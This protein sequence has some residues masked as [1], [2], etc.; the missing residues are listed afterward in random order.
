M[1]RKEISLQKW[2][3]GYWIGMFLFLVA[4]YFLAQAYLFF[5]F[6]NRVEENIQKSVSI[7]SIGIEDSLDV[8]DG[9]IYEALYSGTTQS[10]SQLYNALKNESDPVA[11]LAARSSVVA[12]LKSI[13]TWSDMIDFILLYTDREDEPFWMESGT[14]DTFYARTEVKN[15]LLDSMEEQELGN[16]DR[17][18]I[19]SGNRHNYMLRLIKIEGSYLVVGVSEQ[20]ILSTLLGF[21]YDEGGIA[22]AADE[23]G[24]VIFSSEPMTEQLFLSQEGTYITVN[25]KE[26]LQTGYVSNATGYYFGLLTSKDSIESDM[27]IFRIVFV[28][29]FLVLMLLVPG[30]FYLISRYVEKPIE[31]LSE[32]M[33]Q[34]SE[35]EL[36][37]MVEERPQ[38]M[39]LAQ[40]VK[41]FNHMI[42]RI[43]K[44]K[45][46]IPCDISAEAAFL[47]HPS[48]NM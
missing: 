28:M 33:N 3:Q 44:L 11:L 19:C 42:E 38:I 41:S 5:A 34:I 36:E 43:K 39:E 16:L 4:V 29:A 46:E 21:A 22:F 2:L 48:S 9:F 8:V 40:L 18:M 7:A 32:T 12:S 30:S 37:V 45:I 17:Y 15:Y 26:Y 35:G 13:T 1:K 25:E 20:K 6:T 47:Y 23:S 10:T 14:A 24:K 31:T 27:Q